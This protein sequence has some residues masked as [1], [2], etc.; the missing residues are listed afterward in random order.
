MQNYY[1]EVKKTGSPSNCFRE[2]GWHHRTLC[3]KSKP[4][5][6]QGPC[7]SMRLRLRLVEFH[8]TRGK[9]SDQALKGSAWLSW[10]PM[11]LDLI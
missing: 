5:Y 6:F 1:F 3:S 9:G 10:T 2:L 11:A 7:C 8:R 4:K